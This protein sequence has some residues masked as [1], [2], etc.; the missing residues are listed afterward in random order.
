M[1]EF[2][3]TSTYHFVIIIFHFIPSHSIPS[4]VSKFTMAWRNSHHDRPASFYRT[5][6]PNVQKPKNGSEKKRNQH[7][8]TSGLTGHEWALRTAIWFH[9]SRVE[10]QN[11]KVKIRKKK[12]ND[13]RSTMRKKKLWI[14]FFSMTMPP[15]P[16]TPFLPLF[17]I[18]FFPSPVFQPPPKKRKR[19]KK[20]F[21]MGRL[22]TLI[23]LLLC[24]KKKK[25]FFWGGGGK[26]RSSSFNGY[27]PTT[28]KLKSLRGQGGGNWREGGGG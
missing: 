10:S 8:K 18:F 23:L 6:N 7:K 22:L 12:K 27:D 2:S 24:K 28:E 11:S 26:R 21:M 5:S 14:N 17:S 4:L 3:S 15:L 25:N 19:K 13:Q 1:Y 20:T 9:T 16:Q